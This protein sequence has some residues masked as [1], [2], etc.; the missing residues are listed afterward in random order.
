MIKLA[1]LFKEGIRINIYD[2]IGLVKGVG[3]KLKERL[4]K[5]GIFTVLDL[6][7]YFPRDYEFLNDDIS[8][9]GDISDEKAILKCKVQSYGS[10]IRTRNGKTL[11]T[12]N[13]TY[14]NLK[15]IG[16]WFNQPYIKRNF[17]LGNEYNLMGKFKK[18]NNTLEVINP[19]IPCKEANKSE[20]LPIYTLKNGL[21]NKIL[22]K[23]INEILKNMIIKENLPEEIVKKYKLISLDKAIR[24]I[25]FPEGRGEL[26][27][28]INRLKF[29]EL[30]T[31][32]LKIIM[33]KAHIKKENSGISFKMSP[34]LKELKES[35]P[36]TLTNAQSR[37]LREILLDQKRNIAMNRL[38]Q[39]DVGSG[40]TLVA[41]ISMFNVYMNGYQTVLMAPTEILANQHYAEAKKYLDKFGVDI[42][43]LTGSTKE[44]EKKRIKEK[45][46][47]GKEIML[48]GTH[49]LI[50]DDVEL[51]N[52]GLVVTDEQHRFGV[53]Q[54]SRLINKNK[55]ADV[56]VMTATPIPRTLSLYLYSDLDIS[57]IDELPPGRKPID[58]MLVDM[59][60]R[61]KAYNFALKEVE[62]G[63]QF[64][65]VSPL[66]E[67]NEK[68]NLNSVEK[69]YEELKNGIFKDVRIEILHGKMAGKD[70]DKIINTFKNGEIKGI[71]STT[72]IE[73]GV[74][75]PNS[76]MMII[77]NAER[78][79]L[80]QLHQ[81]RGRVGR[82]EH[83]SYC[84]LIANTKNDITRRRME[85]M[86]ESSDGF[87]IA[88]ED[89]KLRGAGEVFG[90][91]QHGDEGFIL[92]NV[93]DDI[94]ILK[95]ANHEAKLI[96]NNINEDNKKLCT[97]IMRG[98]ERNS[99]YICF[100]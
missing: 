79:G 16:K 83:K 42:E 38:V 5:V 75:V 45:I 77:E 78:F 52:L 11:T 6:L 85:I 68:L 57:I 29:Q 44:K 69:I 35:L 19:L 71:I 31:Y 21:T 66:I 88:E 96:V 17:I 90:M 59:N 37:T 10:S 73:V 81:L 50:Q 25:H 4:N 80:A 95:C 56:L 62:K 51:N 18:V 97:E 30:F 26:Q 70:K 8:L 7:L 54:R 2:D 15:V 53:E 84:I 72:V 92:A 91:R 3:P 14:N 99:R 32:S 27:S 40:K 82:G 58:T 28:A 98:I 33:M 49:A 23:L 63:R 64:Y 60:Q 39:G 43:L 76:T 100:N 61:M 89:L 74:N 36:Y 13:F 48:I 65:I 93:V 1:L 22:V 67:E 34:L 55:R 94:N 86:T 24:S 9:N 47:S 46:A 87:Y 12:I 41:L 20:I